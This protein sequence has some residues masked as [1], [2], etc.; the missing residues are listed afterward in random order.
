M[1][2]GWPA[3]RRSGRRGASSRSARRR[4]ARRRGHAPLPE[5]GANGSSLISEPASTGIHSSSSEVSERMMRV[6]AWPRSPSRTMS[7]PAR[8]AFSSCGTG[9]LVAE[10]AGEQLLPGL[11]PPRVRDHRRDRRRHRPRRRRRGDLQPCRRHR[12]RR[13]LMGVFEGGN[14]SPADE[15]PGRYLGAGSHPTHRSGSHRPAPGGV[16][17]GLSRVGHGCH[18]CGAE[19]RHPPE[20][21]AAHRGRR[22]RSRTRTVARRGRQHRRVDRHH[23]GA[24]SLVAPSARRSATSPT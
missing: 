10:H 18:P 24:R 5:I 21:D 16:H 23:R 3:S 20:R 22:R 12:R 6:L 4:R 13:A 9:L 19:Q 15:P 17:I 2:R 8:M 1:C 7:C 11:R 14:A